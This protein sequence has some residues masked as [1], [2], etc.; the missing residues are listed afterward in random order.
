MLSIFHEATKTDSWYASS[1][2]WTFLL[3][4]NNSGSIRWKLYDEDHCKLKE[5]TRCPSLCRKRHIIIF[6]I[7]SFIPCIMHRAD[8]SHLLFPSC[9]NNTVSTWSLNLTTSFSCTF[10][11]DKM[12]EN[13]SIRYKL[14]GKLRLWWRCRNVHTKNRR[15]RNEI[16]WLINANL[17]HNHAQ[18]Q[19]KC[20]K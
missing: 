2:Q 18:T 20:Q 5:C 12:V 3:F 4:T 15:F 13:R 10:L 14:P 16:L 8:A 7:V 17:M 19:G 1:Q 11:N 6:T 9:R